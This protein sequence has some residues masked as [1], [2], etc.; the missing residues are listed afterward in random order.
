MSYESEKL[1]IFFI[2]N[3]EA[4]KKYEIAKTYYKFAMYG[5]NN[6]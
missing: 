1:N 3:L 2:E 4:W 6:F 5:P